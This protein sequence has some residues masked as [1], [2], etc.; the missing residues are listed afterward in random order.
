MKREKASTSDEE[1]RKGIVQAKFNERNSGP[2]TTEIIIISVAAGFLTSS[3][4]IFFLT[5]FFLIG[6]LKTPLGVL[7]VVLLSSAWGLIVGTIA[8]SAWGINAGIVCGLIALMAT[9]G[10]RRAGLQYYRDL[11]A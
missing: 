1:V 2:L 3:W 7:L 8:Y 9:Y 11:S 4:W 5:L 10:G 6:I